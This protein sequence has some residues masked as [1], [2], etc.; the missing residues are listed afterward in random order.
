MAMSSGPSMHSGGPRPRSSSNV[1]FS[2][3]E[4]LVAAC[5]SRRP[6]S[7]DHGGSWVRSQSWGI[8]WIRISVS[9]IIRRFAGLTMSRTSSSSELTVGSAP[10]SGS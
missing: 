7:V 1:R 5:G 3:N 9:V 10:G 6:R 4:P 2:T 8:T